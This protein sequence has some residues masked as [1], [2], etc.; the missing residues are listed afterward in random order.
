V[1]LATS[2]ATPVTLPP[3][4][5]DN[6]RLDQWVQFETPG[7]VTVSTGRVEIGQ[8]V[9]TA[10]L[11]IAA[12][13]LDVLPNRVD[14]QTGDT[15][16]TPN[17]GYTAG[18]QSIQ[19]GGIAM[20][21]ACAEV[22]SQFLAAA[23][24]RLKCAA[25]DL[26][27]TDGAVFHQGTAT[28]QDYWSLADGVDLTRSVTGRVAIKSATEYRVVGQNTARIDLAD[29]VFG[30]PVFIHDMKLDGM[31]HARVVRQPHCGGTVANID[32]A[33]ICRAGKGSVEIIRHGD[34]I[35]ILGVDETVVD[36]AAS[37][38]P[39]HVT[40][41]GIDP[42]NPLQE[43]ARWL[44]QQPTIDQS[45]GAP[46]PNDPL[47]ADYEASFSRM[48]VAHASIGPSCGLALYCEGKLQVWTH[49]Q[50]VY[51]LRAALARTLKIDPAAISVK[52]V[53][54]PGCYG[55][56]GADDAAADAAVI[57]V[58]KPCTPIRVRWRREE[59]F[60]FE[61]VS[62][63]MVVTVRATLNATG[64]PIDW[65]TE[66]WSGKH[67][68]RPGSG[69]NL[70]AAEALPDPPPSPPAFEAV[71]PPGAG[72]RN[73]EPLYSF[74]A[75]RIVH[76]LIPETPVRTSS[77]RGLGATVNVFA[78][79][80]AMDDLAARAGQDPVAY[81]LSV[82]PDPRARACIERVAR[83]CGWQPSGPAGTGH[84]R[85]IGFARYKNM[86]GYAAVVAEVEVDE[87]VRVL[88][89]WCAADGGLVIN[90]DGAINQLEGGIIQGVS[91][92]LKEG[93]RLDTAGISSRDW[94]S[95]PV[96][97]FS[98]APELFVELINPLTDLPPLGLGE[99][100]GGPTV[101][102]IGNAVNQALGA[103]IRE[104]P[105]T[106]ERVMATLLQD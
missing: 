77:L 14:L 84:G 86:A 13:E 6:P 15:A 26:S 9:L 50:G 8:G 20:R 43:E 93:V 38:A 59:E 2:D 28:G 88:N 22:R 40:W 49:S 66:I 12:D 70:L 101:A 36:T 72:T 21:L 96:L 51:P 35:A 57:A 11:Q 10:M 87:N 7:R 76:H 48:H 105:M 46:P 65:T 95:Y 78:I 30:A 73:G 82:L 63:A 67:V 45:L 103:R 5:K 39:S 47:Q 94:D 98:E 41:D 102:A 58:L 42:I 23:A 17:E 61:P 68:N 97:R 24:S 62:P 64:K 54:G 33:A 52:H 53:Q 29:K 44:L 60:G 106:R 71:G 32:E 31:V 19:F 85:G 16:L 27:I 74:A 4:L 25:A 92:A 1:P 83:M 56:N 37:V 75:R 99:A 80:A 81:R 91:W 3:L 100:T 90:P 104:L 89:V 55:H 79:E 34:F 69:G 18:S